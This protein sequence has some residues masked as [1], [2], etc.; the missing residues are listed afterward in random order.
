MRLN[1]GDLIL[2]DGDH[3]L[4]RRQ[5]ERTGCR[6]TQ[7][8]L[9]VR[10]S[11]AEMWVFESTKISPC[12][13]VILGRQVTGVQ[14]ARLVDRVATFDGQIAVRS[15]SPQLDQDATDTLWRFIRGSH[16]HAFNES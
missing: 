13:D 2:Y 10:P 16:G 14:L 11:D 9:L 3:P 15:L 1:S 4:H 6:W 5:R 8:A 7:V 12:P